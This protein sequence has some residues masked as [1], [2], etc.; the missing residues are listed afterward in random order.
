MLTP[1]VPPPC[2]PSEASVAAETAWLPEGVVKNHLLLW[3]PC[4]KAARVVLAHGAL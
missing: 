3:G 1:T 4:P 2:R